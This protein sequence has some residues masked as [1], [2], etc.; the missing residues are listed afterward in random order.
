V[1]ELTEDI[2]DRLHMEPDPAGGAGQEGSVIGRFRRPLTWITPGTPFAYLTAVSIILAGT[3]IRFAIGMTFG[4]GIIPF[5]TYFPGVLFTTL[6]AGG[7]AGALATFLGAVIGYK[8]FAPMF[9]Q[10]SVAATNPIIS[11]ALY[12]VCSGLIIAIAMAYRTAIHA[13]WAEQEKTRM[14]SRELEHRI[15]NTAAMIQALIART[16]GA[17]NPDTKI[18][19]K[20]IAA[21]TATEPLLH[22]APVAAKLRDVATR[23]LE[24]YDLSRVKISGEDLLVS[25]E[26]T[27][28]AVLLFHELATNAAK[29]GALQTSS[30]TVDVSWRRSGADILVDWTEAGGPPVCPPERSGFGTALMEQVVTNIKGNITVAYPP[31]GLYAQIRIPLAS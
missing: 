31:T 27:L 14:L 23:E 13:L 7:R 30:G 8:F 1:N 12:I 28:V 10:T 2:D 29:H 17:N 20:R 6:V 24:P 22:H 19:N 5:A 26:T 15:R 16:L 4:P 25:H 21:I 3:A 9:Y 18:L 11:V